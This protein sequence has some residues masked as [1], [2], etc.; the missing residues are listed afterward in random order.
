MNVLL[1]R[2]VIR[3]RR[4]VLHSGC[5]MYTIQKSVFRILTYRVTGSYLTTRTEYRTKFVGHNQ[6]TKKFSSVYSVRY[7]VLYTVCSQHAS[8]NTQRD[9]LQ[10]T[11]ELIK[12]SVYNATSYCLITGMFGLFQCMHRASFIVFITTNF[13]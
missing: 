7:T 3:C 1:L 8:I 11:S 4:P 5:I 6:K 10:K 12:Y 13:F 9:I 2:N